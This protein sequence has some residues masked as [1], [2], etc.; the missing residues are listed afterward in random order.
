MSPTEESLS[1]EN[2][3]D[4]Q[5]LNKVY[6]I[7]FFVSLATVLQISESLIPH[8]IP[9]IR[10]GL[11]NVITLIS[12]VTLGFGPTLEIAVLRTILSSFIMGTFM[13]PTFIL[14]FSGAI[15]STVIM[16]SFYWL[17][18][19]HQHY[20]FSL[21]GISVIGALTHNITQLCLAYFLLIKHPGIFVFLPWLCIAAV[22]MG[23][24]TGLVAVNVCR[25][26]EEPR[27]LLKTDNLFQKPK[28]A[29]SATGIDHYLPGTS[30][31]HRMPARIKMAGLLVMSVLVLAF[32]NFWLYLGLFAGFAGLVFLA[33]ISWASLLFRARKYA[34][35]ILSAFLFPALFLA[36]G[37]V[38]YTFAWFRITIEGLQSGAFFGARILFLILANSLLIQTTS[39]EEMSSGLASLL[40]PFRVFGFSEKRIALIFSLSM[41]AIPIFWE[42][43]SNCIKQANLKKVRNISKLIPLLSTIIVTL[44]RETELPPSA[45]PAVFSQSSEVI[46]D[47]NSA[48]KHI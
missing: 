9:G 10:L 27:A 21:V 11:A 4:K 39:I 45:A 7:V 12:L 23:W 20:R 28:T 22:I 18:R 26:L 19:W 38:L 5:E 42:T 34:F 3:V 16:G 29:G 13:S 36:S 14:S 40:A 32:T 6:K 1:A 2:F 25:K 46:I 31:L 48:C 37:Q 35:L 44:Y 43:A 33:R 41:A 8:P 47:L 15:L 17:S 30:F 24:V